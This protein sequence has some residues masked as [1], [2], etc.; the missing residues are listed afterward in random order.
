MLERGDSPTAEATSP[1]ELESSA[2]APD[3]PNGFIV[4]L[5]PIGCDVP[6]ECASCGALASSSRALRRP[7]DGAAI[8]VP[9]CDACHACASSPRTRTLSASLASCL[10]AL[11]LASALPAVF[12]NVPALLLALLVNVGALSPLVVGEVL[13]RSPST[14]RAGVGCA[15]WWTSSGEL[16]CK[17]EAWAAELARR[18]QCA[19][20]S[21]RISSSSWRW[22][23]VAGPLVGS[24]LIGLFYPFY[25]PRVRILN[26]TPERLSVWVDGR[27]E[28]EVE[29][30]STENPR[31][32]VERRL[33]AGNR[34]LEARTPSGRV[35]SRVNVRITGGGRHLYAPG[36]DGYCFWLE[37]TAYGLRAPAP[38]N[39]TSLISEQ[40]FWLVPEGV[41]TWFSPNP[42]PAADDRSTG[43]VLLALRQA[44]CDKAPIP[45]EP[46]REAR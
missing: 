10:V 6:P 44:P 23:Y 20:R 27:P 35:V 32:G 37:S 18:N 41:D 29:P 36:S 8:I 45:T 17:Y 3:E 2:G 13:S 30:T 5:D 22:S 12:G 31:A 46:E 43:G 15:A 14:A 9:Y 19:I 1:D 39:V 21:A 11:T 40:R 28:A 16:A 34:L 38:E 33:P 26:L 42:P 7:R 25:H 24:V 4:T